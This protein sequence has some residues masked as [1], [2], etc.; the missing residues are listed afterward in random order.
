MKSVLI[1]G[2]S[3]FIGLNLVEVFL[4]EGWRVVALS[5]DGIPPYAAAQLATAPG[6]LIDVRGDVRDKALLER[7]LAGQRFDAVVA[8]AAITAGATREQAVPA[9]IFEVNVVAVMRLL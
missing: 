2:A 3:G 9:E 4:A 6:E 7:V 5:L 1:T 8:G